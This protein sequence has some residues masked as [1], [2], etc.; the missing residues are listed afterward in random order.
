MH[1]A[2]ITNQINIIILSMHQS[3]LFFLNNK[4]CHKQNR[5]NCFDSIQTDT[6]NHNVPKAQEKHLFQ[7]Y[8]IGILA[9]ECHSGRPLDR[10]VAT[11]AK[12]EPADI[13]TN[14]YVKCGFGKHCLTLQFQLSFLFSV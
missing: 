2:Q 11:R 10:Y 8:Q 3:Q 13:T 4:R 6:T 1:F 14:H 5:K 9:T 12:L 7:A